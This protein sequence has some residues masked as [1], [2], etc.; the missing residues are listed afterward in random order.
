MARRRELADV[1]DGIGGPFIR[2]LYYTHKKNPMDALERAHSQGLGV[3]YTFDLAAGT[4]DPTSRNLAS[5]AK[6][7]AADLDRHLQVRDIN[8]EWVTTATLTVT[9]NE[10]LNGKR[11]LGPYE[12]LV[13][14]TDDLGTTHTSTRSSEMAELRDLT[15]SGIFFGLIGFLFGGR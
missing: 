7:L 1:A 2:Q 11:P 5:L 4:A 9:F 8:P 12:C 10:T 15:L 13:T 6:D 3:S 14:I